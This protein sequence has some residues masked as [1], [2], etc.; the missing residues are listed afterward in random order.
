V[1][2]PNGYGNTHVPP[3]RDMAAHDAASPLIR[4][5]ANYAV[6]KWSSPHL[7]RYVRDAMAKDGLNREAATQQLMRTMRAMERRDTLA[8]YGPQHPEARA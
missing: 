3:D 5:L 8:H 4:W 6:A 7:G 2:R 1:S